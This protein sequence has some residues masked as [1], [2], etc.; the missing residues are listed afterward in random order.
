MARMTTSS[1][2]A[3]IS[4]A[5]VADSPKIVV[6]S[7]TAERGSAEPPSSRRSSLLVVALVLERS[8]LTLPE[9]DTLPP[10]VLSVPEALPPD[11]AGG[12]GVLTVA[13]EELEPDCPCG[14]GADVELDDEDDC[15]STSDTG[16]ASRATPSKA[17][18]KAFITAP[19]RRTAG[20]RPVPPR[21]RSGKEPCA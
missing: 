13:D 6:R 15:A 17:A 8:E 18:N 20:A 16:A 21:G 3:A 11:G 1:S 7:V 2:A 10:G 12:G 4:T 9:P 19:P 14:A 5:A